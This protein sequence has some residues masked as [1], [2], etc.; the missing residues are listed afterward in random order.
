MSNFVRVDTHRISRI[1][2]GRKKMWKWRR[3][4]GKHNK[5]RLKRFS[6]PIQPGIGFGTPRKDAG[7]IKGLYPILITNMSDLDKADKNNILII[8]RKLGAKKKIDLL[9]KASE[10]NLKIANVGGKKWI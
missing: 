1:G 8:S 6:Y 2:K 9:K 3:P 10:L 4:T 7:K 5:T